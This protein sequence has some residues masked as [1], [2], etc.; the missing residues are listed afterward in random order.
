VN[1]A[2][3]AAP[4]GLIRYPDISAREIVFTYADDLWLVARDGGV[5]RR[6]T[7]S[8]GDKR[9]RFSPDGTRLAYSALRDGRS[10]AFVLDRAGGVPR[11]LS[12]HPAPTRV[13]GWTPDGRSVL[14]ASTM[15]SER[16]NFNRLFLMPPDGGLP[17]A[18][19]LPFGE[20]GAFSPDGRLLAYT[21]QRDQQEESWKRYRGGRAP[22]LWLFDR[23]SGTTRP[24]TD[25]ASP[26]SEPIWIGTRIYFL[27]ER[28][29]EQRSNLWVVDAAGGAPRQLTRYADVDVRFPSGGSGGIVFTIAGRLMRLDPATERVSAVEVEIADERPAPGARAVGD[30]FVNVDAGAAGQAAIEA[31]GDVFTLAV[32]SGAAQNRSA[33]P[34]AAER[35]PALA[36]DGRTLAYFSDADGEYQLVLRDLASNQ[37]RTLT[38]FTEGLRFKPQ[39]SPDSR[40]IVFI[41][42]RGDLHLVDAASGA[43][44]VVMR[45]L[46]IRTMEPFD[47]LAAFRVGW[48][49]DSRWVA[50]ASALANRNHALFVVDTRAA[51]ATP[52]TQLTS[53]FANDLAPVFDPRGDY[54]Y[55]LSQRRLA[56]V[57]G[58]ID[59]VWT[60]ANSSTIS[61]IPLRADVADPLD[62][63]A[64]AAARGAAPVQPPAVT[65]ETSGIEERLVTLPLPDTRIDAF[66]ASADRLVYL[67]RTPRGAAGAEAGTL[68]AFRLGAT[69]ATEL[70]ANVDE[71][72]PAPNGRALVVRRGRTLA[73]IDIGVEGATTER[74]LRLETLIARVDPAQEFAQM[75]REAWRYHRDF[76]YDPSMHGQ[77]WAQVWRRHAEWLPRLNGVNDLGFALRELSGELGAGHVVASATP[78]SRETNPQRVGLLGADVERRDGT[79]RIA[80]VL[81]AGLRSPE[82]RSPLAAPGV[83]VR[84]GDVLLAINGQSLA[85]QPDPWVALIGLAEQRVRLTIAPGGDARAPRDV[86][87]RC[88][89][90]E[91]KLR[92][93][94]WVERTR[95]RVL[96]LSGGQVGY[97][98]VPDTQDN[99]QNDLVRQYR[100]QHQLPALLV[101][102][103][104]NRGGALGDRLVELLNR[105]ALAYFHVRN[106]ADYPLPTIGH[107]GPK[108]LLI[109]GW[110]YS[111]GDGFPLLFRNARLGPL[112]GS[113][114]AGGLVGPG[115]YLPLINGGVVSAPPQRVYDPDGRWSGGRNDGV[116]PDIEVP[117]D[118]D[119]L[120]HGRDPHIE[121]GVAVLLKALQAAPPRAR[122]PAVEAQP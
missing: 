5:A 27:S 29:A 105:P 37:A 62:A 122:A 97:L 70:A 109:N 39:W 51:A 44:R 111:G 25:G 55:C 22:K 53:G 86:W 7:S 33:T 87:V 100:A 84:A 88:L 21:W 80:R 121:Q 72:Q 102:E 54:L 89:A 95:R 118:P 26:D 68:K 120:M 3:A 66:S 35:F 93:L 78:R 38:R 2:A 58:D 91:Q 23:S 71:M 107:G 17:E 112:I 16:P 113:R 61:A 63:L 103:R 32:A 65:I 77:D 36:P 90:D 45:T 31:H 8:G 76:F 92:E 19:P 4:A 99:G 83:N 42:W 14:V 82:Q 115:L 79:V 69:T 20:T 56:P 6:L 104:F 67:A 81:D 40:Q 52:P 50:F 18:L 11:P 117:T 110:S 60:Y 34:N 96:E 85:A 74:A 57:W 101:D 30:Q 46:Q 1:A 9:A 41:D 13:A 98:Y 64:L 47:D 108:A 15:A 116:P 106:G 73:W 119:A 43:R 49:P 59:D 94:D 28:G 10:Q 114:T 48:S 12:H 24:L 75:L